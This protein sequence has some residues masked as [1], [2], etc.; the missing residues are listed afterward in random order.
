VS[1]TALSAPLDDAVETQ[2]RAALH[3]RFLPIYGDRVASYV[4]DILGLDHYQARFDYLLAVIGP[5]DATNPS[6]IL[7]SGFSVGSE[8]VAA[9]RAGFGRISGVEVDSFLVTTCATRLAHLAEMYPSYYDGLTLPYEDALFDVVA[10][11]H[12]IEHT[13]NPFVYLKECL[14]V[15]RPGGHLSLEFPTRYHHTELHTRLPSL[16]WLPRPLRNLGLRLLRGRLSPFSKDVKRRYHSILDTN[17]QQ[18][19]MGTVRR[20]LADSGFASTVLKC[21]KVSPG[22]IRCVIRRDGPRPGSV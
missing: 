15:L 13:A 22:V 9:R 11:G 20:Y 12:I 1:P 5:L 4:G 21:E 16:E 2:V 8:M 10:S 19:S 7:I 14:R 18:I 6:D 17:L 3:E